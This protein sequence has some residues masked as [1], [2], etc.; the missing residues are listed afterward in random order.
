M[1]VCITSFVSEA[2]ID[3]DHLSITTKLNSYIF[4]L[5]ICCGINRSSDRSSEVNA[6]V[7]FLYFVNWMNPHSKSG[8]ESNEL[9]IC[10]GLDGW[11]SREKFFFLL[12]HVHDL[13]L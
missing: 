1:H 11:D 7:H 9:F 4:N 13:I 12:G 2:M 10:N 5:T 8:S 6:R 3:D